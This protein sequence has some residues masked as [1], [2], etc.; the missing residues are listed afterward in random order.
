MISHS[1][2]RERSTLQV[3]IHLYCH[4]NHH[5]PAELCDDCRD[6]LEYAL[7]R[8]DRCKFQENKPVC[9]RC[10][11]HCYKPDMREKVR[12]V[13][14]YAGPRMLGRHPLLALRH[15]WDEVTRPPAGK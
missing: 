3:M 8:L 2:D 12:L 6:L 13:M 9:G 5:P 4:D 7:K 11:V 15:L 1:L 14:R 10:T